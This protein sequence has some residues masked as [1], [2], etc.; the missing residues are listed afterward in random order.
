MKIKFFGTRGYIE[1][2]NRRHK[3][4]TV[5]LV[6]YKK[7]KLMIDCGIDWLGKFERFNPTAIVITHAHPDHAWGL[8]NGSPCPVYATKESWDIMQKY[9]IKDKCIVKPRKKFKIGL[10]VLE[11]FFVE[12]SI[13]APAVGYRIIGDNKIIFCAHDLIFIPE[14][15][16]ALAGVRLY[17][18]DGASISRPIIRRKGDQLFGHTTIRAQLDWCKKEGVP[19][20]IFTHC[21][22]QIVT[23]DERKLGARVKRLGKRLGLDARIAYDGMEVNVL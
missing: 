3:R 7:T 8:K 10:L 9:P 6:I 13:R 11:A 22:S 1:A 21:G 15:K 2:K 4:H 5:T 19:Y 12:H 18:G 16:K 20:A 23:G 14:V 17:I